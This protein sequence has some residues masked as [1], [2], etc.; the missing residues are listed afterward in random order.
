MDAEASYTASWNLHRRIVAAPSYEPVASAAE[1]RG[2][3]SSFVIATA[4]IPRSSFAPS[5]DATSVAANGVRAPSDPS[6]GV[7]S[8]PEDSSRRVKRHTRVAP[9]IPAVANAGRSEARLDDE[10]G[11]DRPG[12][13]IARVGPAAGQN[14]EATLL[15]DAACAWSTVA[16][17]SQRDHRADMPRERPGVR[18]TN[19][20]TMIC[21][22]HTSVCG[23][24]RYSRLCVERQDTRVG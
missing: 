4:R 22:R 18:R 6:L 19:E 8:T 1:P 7:L 17:M 23:D 10:A 20:T 16:A 11:A 24:Q 12:T 15:T 13:E 3:E 14:P 5:T 2:S 9:S 21:S